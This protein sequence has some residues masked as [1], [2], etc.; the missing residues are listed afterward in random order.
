MSKVVVGTTMSLDGFINDR[1]GDLSTLYPDLAHLRDTEVLQES[2]KSTGAAVMGRRTYDL[3]ES[4][5]TGYEYQVP[6]FVL[7]HHPPEHAPKGENENLTVTF[8]NDSI[9]SA[10][11]QAKAAA[12]DKDVV[13]IGGASTAQQIINAGLADEL[14]IGVVPILLG[15]GLRFFEHL[16][17]PQ[18]ELEKIKLLESPGRT[19]IMFRVVPRNNTE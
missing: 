15:E 2:M 16:D 8:V 1:N 19:D 12:G 6:I 3:A 17:E 9:E 10:V 14:H 5:L 7:T 4:D 11:K 13:V 18:I